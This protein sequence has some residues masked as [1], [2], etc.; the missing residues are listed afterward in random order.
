MSVSMSKT[1]L[2][3]CPRQAARLTAVAVLPQPP[4][5]LAIAITF[6]AASFE[7]RCRAWLAPA[8]RR[9]LHQAASVP[10]GAWPISITPVMKVVAAAPVHHR[11][12]P[13]RCEIRAEGANLR[14]A[15]RQRMDKRAR[16]PVISVS[17]SPKTKA[18]ASKGGAPIYVKTGL[19]VNRAR[20]GGWRDGLGRALGAFR[21]RPHGCH[22]PIADRRRAIPSET[23][24]VRGTTSRRRAYVWRRA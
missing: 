12:R 1:R 21:D 17:S 16:V 3:C 8:K 19:S 4:L 20:C 9:Q 22:L 6:I 2:P 14:A 23:D 24:S 7:N 11:L 10:A 5:R 18:V 15:V 13:T